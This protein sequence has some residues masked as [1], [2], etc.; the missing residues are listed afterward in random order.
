VF[1]N[2]AA[3]EDVG[4]FGV[5]GDGGIGV[6]QLEEGAKLLEKGDVVGAF[7]KGGLGPAADEGGDGGGI[8]GV[9]GDVRRGT[10]RRVGSG[11]A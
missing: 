1:K 4:V 9:G 3:L 10:V 11:H 7:G 5:V 8:G 6:R 2:D